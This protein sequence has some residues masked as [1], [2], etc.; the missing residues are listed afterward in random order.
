VAARLGRLNLWT[1]GHDDAFRG[2]AD[3]MQTDPFRVAFADLIAS[4][5]KRRTAIMCAETLWWKCHRRLIADAAVLL[6][7]AA[8][9][10]LVSGKAVAHV[11]TTEAIVTGDGV[12]YPG[13]A[14]RFDACNGLC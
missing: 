11:L 14:G 8:V 2:Y 9:T 10:H 4:A 1:V 12:F 13:D 6:R 7:D 5:A 3:W